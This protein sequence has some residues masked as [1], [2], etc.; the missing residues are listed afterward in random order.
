MQNLPVAHQGGV[1]QD[2]RYI[3]MEHNLAT[4]MD[5]MMPVLRRQVDVP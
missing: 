4:L 2:G 1:A 3:N 5:K